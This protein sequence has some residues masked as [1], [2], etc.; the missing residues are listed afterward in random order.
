M[1]YLAK[2]GCVLQLHSYDTSWCLVDQLTANLCLKSFVL[3]SSSRSSSSEP[4][5]EEDDIDDIAE[6]KKALEDPTPGEV[7]GEPASEPAGE[8]EVCKLNMFSWLWWDPEDAED[9]DAKVLMFAMFCH[10]CWWLP[11]IAGASTPNGGVQELPSGTGLPTTAA[12]EA[13]DSCC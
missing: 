12:L 9:A 11:V 7:A 4:E 13:R 8:P 10:V 2:D 3:L 6:P 5:E 1:V